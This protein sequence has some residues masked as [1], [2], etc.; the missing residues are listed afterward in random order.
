MPFC[1]RH[2]QEEGQGNCEASGR[3]RHVP[4]S[5]LHRVYAP[6]T[7]VALSLLSFCRLLCVVFFEFISRVLTLLALCWVAHH[8]TLPTQNMK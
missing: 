1:K 2:G 8:P 4:F 5:W 6:T 3:E 7:F